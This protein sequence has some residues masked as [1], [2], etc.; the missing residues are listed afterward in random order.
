M[1]VPKEVGMAVLFSLA[2]NPGTRQI[3]AEIERFKLAEEL[4]YGGL[5]LSESLM[6]GPDPFQVMAL[7]AMQTKKIRLGTAIMTLSFREPAVIANSAA[8]LND[9]SS[10]RVV[11]G[12]G[13]GDGTTYTMGRTA[14]PLS[15]FERSARTLH[16]LLNGKPIAV[17][18]NKEREAGKVPLKAGRFPVPL[19]IAATGPRSLRVAGRVADGV[20]MGV[21]FDMGAFAWARER[22]AEGA[23]EVGRSVDEI[24]LM[25]AGIMCVDENRNRARELAR[26]RLANRAHHNFRFTLETVPEGEVEGVE[27]FMKHFDVTKP[28]DQ[29][30]NPQLVTEYLVSRFSIAGTPSE[31]IERVQELKGAG[32]DRVLLTLPPSAYREVMRTWSE[33]VMPYC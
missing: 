18:K 14:T 15:V 12:L 9:I 31:C 6:S 33:K 26:G 4:G 20:I 22:I 32:I 1:V 13:T 21:G 7:A 19:Y 30:S 27:T 5:F 28:I 10:G 23:A 11:L 25:G 3:D 16:D 17:P 2:G 29:R 8:T 24:E